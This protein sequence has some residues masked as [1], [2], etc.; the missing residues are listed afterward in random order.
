MSKNLYKI[1][2][3]KKSEAKPGSLISA[4]NANKAKHGGVAL[5]KKRRKVKH[6]SSCGSKMHKTHEH[7]HEKHRKDT[8]KS[9]NDKF[10]R[11]AENEERIHGHR[12]GSKHFKH[13]KEHSAEAI[14]GLEKFA[15]EESKEKKHGK[16]RKNWIAGAIKHPGALHRELGVKQ[17]HKIPAS[18]LAAA[19]KKGGKIGKRAR[20][21]ETLKGFHH[22]KRKDFGLMQFGDRSLTNKGAQGNENSTVMGTNPRFFK[23]G[24]KA[25]KHKNAPNNPQLGENGSGPMVGSV[26]GF[27]KRSKGRKK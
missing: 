4:L 20:L 18:R 19:A 25:K 27:K 13:K 7:R 6:C 11:V 22:K 10:N 3:V 12:S 21:A 2:G 26:G 24:K 9:G 14:K 1:L 5:F 17:G 15:R 16:K 8:E 23:K